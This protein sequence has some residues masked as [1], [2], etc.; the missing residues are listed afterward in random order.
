MCQYMNTYP[1]NTVVMQV[2]QKIVNTQKLNS[3]SFV[4]SSMAVLDVMSKS[5]IATGLASIDQFHTIVNLAKDLKRIFEEDFNSSS[6][7]SVLNIEIL[8][9][10]IELLCSVS[11]GCA[12]TTYLSEATTLIN[13]I[14]NLLVLKATRMH[15]CRI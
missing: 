7:C 5:N 14:L 12:I 10:T 1:G 13:A 4:I 15:K 3:R 6:K 11:H 2:L 9:R 8:E